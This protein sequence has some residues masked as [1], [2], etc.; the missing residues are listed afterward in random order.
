MELLL[1]V[2]FKLLLQS[3]TLKIDL[4]QLVLDD[5]LDLAVDGFVFIFGLA[6]L[7]LSLGL[8]HSSDAIVAAHLKRCFD[9]GQATVLLQ[10]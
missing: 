6:A 8:V 9:Q 10:L 3:P 1:P 7:W 2:L 5:L 4:L